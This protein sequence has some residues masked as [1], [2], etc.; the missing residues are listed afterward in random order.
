VAQKPLPDDI[1]GDLAAHVGCIAGAIEK[2][3]YKDLLTDAGFQG[4]LAF[5]HMLTL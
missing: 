3:V 4:G 2:S 5:L 1:R